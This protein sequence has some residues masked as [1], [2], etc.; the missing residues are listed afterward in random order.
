MSSSDK[1]RNAV[2]L[3]AHGSPDSVEQVPEFLSKVTGGRTLPDAVVNEVRHRYGKVGRFPLTHVTIQQG[4]LLSSRLALPVYVGMRNWHPF[5]A[6]TLARMTADG[7]T[8]ATVICMAPQNSTTSVG[9]YRRS[10]RSA[11]C[12]MTF[13]FVEAW[14]DQPKLVQAFAQ[15]LT[16][17]LASVREEYGKK[18]PVIF[19]A[20]SVPERTILE[21]DPY[22][23]QTKHTAEL[24]AA[25]AGLDRAAWKF[26]FQSQGMSGG[27]W[28]GPT[29]E[30]TI[31]QLKEA[32]HSGVLIQPI[33]FLCDHI[34]ILYDID[35]GFKE[36]AEARGMR[37]WRAESLN[38]APLL[39][40]ALAEIVQS[41]TAGVAAE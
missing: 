20:H 37:L 35:I 26:A 12:G 41:R 29:V 10:L 28:L 1:G 4:E 14:H 25:A 2:L 11:D 5:V 39:T 21:G 22:E 18:P 31:L 38:T 13:D 23:D 17:G 7:I 30:Q 40:E 34:E 27:T 16:A 9:L 8:H 19:T 6:D 36:F 32:G 24:V 15:N 33:G 3:L